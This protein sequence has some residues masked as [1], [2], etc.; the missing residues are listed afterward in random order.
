[1]ALYKWKEGSKA[2]INFPK[3]SLQKQ[4]MVDEKRAEAVWCQDALQRLNCS[5][6]RVGGGRVATMGGEG[7]NW[8]T[9]TLQIG[10]RLLQ[11]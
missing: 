2:E 4:Q 7:D 3:E 10:L 6:R 8:C 5:W 9:S 1:M 11:I